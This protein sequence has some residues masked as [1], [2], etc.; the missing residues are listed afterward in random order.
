MPYFYTDNL[1]SQRLVTRKITLNDIEEWSE[2]FKDKDAVKFLP[3]PDINSTIERS[4][5]W[6]NKQLK[7]YQ[8]NTYGLQALIDKETNQFVGQ[9]GLLGQTIDGKEEIEI[10]YHIFKKHWGKGY[11]PEAAKLFIDYSFNNNITDSVI[12]IIHIDNIKSQR[13]AEKNG[14][15]REKQVKWSN[16]DVFIYRIKKQ[17]Q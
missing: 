16:L 3:N 15:T 6:I 13:V 8:D 9:C 5:F 17:F 11:A 4:A 10:G 7:R 1:Q 14:L 12:S 2:F